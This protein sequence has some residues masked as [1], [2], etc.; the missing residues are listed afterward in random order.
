MLIDCTTKGCLKK[1]EAKLD[2]EKDQVIC[3][4]CGNPI[5]N[6]TKFTKKALKSLGQVVRIKSKQAFQALCKNCND[7]RELYIKEDKAYCKSCNTQVFVS[8]AFL[9]GLKV[10]LESKK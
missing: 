10:Y 8:A 1:S 6:I 4:E 5:D 9:Q 2:V 7:S 3:D